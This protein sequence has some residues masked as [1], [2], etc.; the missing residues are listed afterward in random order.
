M[1]YCPTWDDPFRQ[2]GAPAPRSIYDDINAASP[3]G[4][5]VW[6]DGGLR[7]PPS[8]PPPFAEDRTP[9]N[10]AP[11]IYT[12]QAPR[13]TTGTPNTI[14]TVDPRNCEA[15]SNWASRNWC[16]I[17]NSVIQGPPPHATAGPETI[18]DAQNIAAKI[19]LW[20][21]SPVIIF[22][23]IAVII[24]ALVMMGRPAVAK[25]AG[26]QTAAAVGTIRRAFR[27]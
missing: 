19:M 25:I 17:A 18:K 1:A 6:S 22:L 24:V 14:G 23:G 3:F 9:P 10:V 27:K 16:K 13:L 20:I 2:C 4:Y 8:L 7:A 21:S 26:S 5:D 15:R 11:S 12:P